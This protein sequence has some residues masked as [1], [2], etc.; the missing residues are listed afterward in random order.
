MVQLLTVSHQPGSDDGRPG[1]AAARAIWP[2][3]GIAL[4]QELAD[5]RWHEKNG[6]AAKV[7]ERAHRQQPGTVLTDVARS[8]RAGTMRDA[9]EATAECVS[10][11]FGDRFL[12]AKTYEVPNP[13]RGPS[14]GEFWEFCRAWRCAGA[15]DQ[16]DG[17][18]VGGG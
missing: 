9:M 8:E 12:G 16:C 6:H 13:R 2:G 17:R 11:T 10:I 3:P 15:V 7:R 14:C 1:P 18:A 5:R 4:N